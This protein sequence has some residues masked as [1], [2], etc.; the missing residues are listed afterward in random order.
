[1]KSQALYAHPQQGKQPQLQPGFTSQ[2]EWCVFV[3]DHPVFDEERHFPDRDCRRL[4]AV[5]GPMPQAVCEGLALLTAPFCTVV[6]ATELKAF[7]DKHPNYS[8]LIRFGEEKIIF[9]L[10]D[11]DGCR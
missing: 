11:S 8:S 7:L 2:E 1:M 10:G 6:S 3:R 4:I 5:M 9:F